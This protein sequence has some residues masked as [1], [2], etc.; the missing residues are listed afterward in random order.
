VNRKQLLTLIATI[1]AANVVFLDSTVVS[2]ALPAIQED[3]DTGLAGQQWIVEAYLLTLVSLMLV[4]GSLGDLYGRKRIFVMGLIGFGA[5]SMLCA[6]APSEE[7]LI[8]ARA[9]QGIAGA[10]LVPGSLAILAS[11]FE[12]EARG[13]AVGL[14]TAWAGISTLIGPAG[15]GLL[16]ELDWRW[17]FWI[18][19]PLIAGTVVLALHAVDES[20]DPEACPGIDGVGIVLSALGL[21]GPVFALIE[22]PTRGFG[23]PIVWVPLVAGAVAFAAFVWWEGRAR[24]PMLPLELF[25][26][27]NFSTVNL[28]TL[29][30]YAGLYGSS[31]FLTLFLQQVVGYSPFEA[32]AATTPVTILML[33]L[34][35]R[36]GALA[37]RIGPRVPMGIGPI[38]AAAGV[39][40][41]LRLDSDASYVAD[42]LP[43]TIILGIGLSMTVA[44]LTTTVLDSVEERHMGIGSGVNN[45]VA[46]VA[47]VLAIAALG[48][49]VSAQFTSSVDDRLGDRPLSA[50]AERAVENAKEQP[51]TAGDVSDVPRAEATELDDALVDSSVSAFHLGILISAALMV[52]GGLISLLGVRNPEPR[53]ERAPDRGPGP[54]ATAGECGRSGEPQHAPSGEREPV[55]A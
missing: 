28:A 43:Y 37:S 42:V 30:V 6:V 23:D 3:L 22:Q 41:L 50:P 34:S 31:F 47:G 5:T 2:V 38:I 52:A 51:L 15:G 20:R 45:A 48:A 1:L 4:G 32:G 14:W 7:T 25:R 12:G 46:R 8:G 29:C 33:V 54:A 26:S 55:A 9:L 49:I 13:R 35:G 24:A 19:I 10:M 36:F 27:H 40:W 18:N 21:A 53:P 17:I 11:T 39:V 16:V 44:P